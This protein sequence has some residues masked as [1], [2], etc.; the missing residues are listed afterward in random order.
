MDLSVQI[1]NAHYLFV[2]LSV[3]IFL[4]SSKDVTVIKLLN[5]KYYL[6]KNIFVF[7]T[8]NLF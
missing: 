6:S 2:K 8:Y 5:L 3:D 1:I 7:S 4:I